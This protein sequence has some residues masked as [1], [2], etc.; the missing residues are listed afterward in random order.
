MHSGHV[1]LNYSFQYIKRP[2]Q[3]YSK[4]LRV[5]REKAHERQ[6]NLIDDGSGQQFSLKAKCMKDFMKTKAEKKMKFDEIM[7]RG[8]SNS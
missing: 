3:H 4:S 2:S 7:L 1:K 8:T 6:R 5:D